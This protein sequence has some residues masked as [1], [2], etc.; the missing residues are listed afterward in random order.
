MY[1]VKLIII[2]SEFKNLIL[3]FK[4]LKG[5]VK[6]KRKGCRLKASHFSS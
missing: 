4:S 3:V 6:E 1:I 2:K 5:T